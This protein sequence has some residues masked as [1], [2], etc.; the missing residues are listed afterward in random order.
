MAE[1][2]DLASVRYESCVLG[3]DGRCTRF[4]HDHGSVE[5]SPKGGPGAALSGSPTQESR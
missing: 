3:A 4:S 5:A 2:E 1:S